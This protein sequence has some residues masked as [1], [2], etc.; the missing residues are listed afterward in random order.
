MEKYYIMDGDKN[1]LPADMW[2][3]AAW[4]EQDKDGSKRR[5]AWDKVSDDIQV[6][7]VFLGMNHGYNGS[8]LLFE[9]MVFG[10]EFDNEQERYATYEE[11]EA[12]HQ[13]WLSLVSAVDDEPA[14]Q[15]EA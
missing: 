8:L 10:G 4:V 11:A 12:G 9:T 6:S 5:V 7:T 13:K 15:Q 3:W 2:I 1:V 14:P